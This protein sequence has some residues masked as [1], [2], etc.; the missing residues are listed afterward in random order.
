MKST[1][2]FRDQVGAIS[3]WFEGWNTCEQSVAL[4]SLLKKLCPAQARFLALVLEQSYAPCHD[5]KLQE[6]EAND[7]AYISSLSHESKDR[8]VAYLL[9][10]L[11]LLY[12]GNEEA[13]FQYLSLIPKVLAHSIENSVHIEE[14]R[15]LLSYSLIHPAITMEDRRSLSQWLR[16]LE[17]R[18]SNCSHFLNDA[19]NHY[20]NNS[21]VNNNQ[22]QQSLHNGHHVT[23]GVDLQGDG[24]NGLLNTWCSLPRDGDLLTPVGMNGRLNG[25]G[26]HSLPPGF[27]GTHVPLHHM[28]SAPP[29]GSFT[30]V[31]QSLPPSCLSGGGGLHSPPNY[32]TTALHLNQG[33]FPS[34]EEPTPGDWLC[35]D[36]AQSPP[37]GAKEPPHAPLS[38]QSSVTSSGSGSESHADEHKT[39]FNSDCSG[40]KDVPAWLKS[41]RLHKYAHLF[42]K[43]SYEEMLNLSETQL[44]SQHVTK[45]ARHKIILSVVKLRERPA[46]LQQL[47]KEVQE[48]GSLKG[49][50]SELRGLIQTPIRSYNGPPSLA[51]NACQEEEGDR[52]PS[53]TSPTLFQQP[54]YFGD[55]AGMFTRVMGKVCANLLVSSRPENECFNMFVML[56][57]KC[58]SHEAFTPTHKRRLFSW[59]QQVQ[60]VWHPLPPRRTL[61]SRQPKGKWLSP[62]GNTT[63]SSTT[64]NGNGTNSVPGDYTPSSLANGSSSSPGG[65]LRTR[66]LTPQQQFPS[67][68]GGV[69]PLTRQH[70]FLQHSGSNPGGLPPPHRSPLSSLVIKRPSLQDHLKPHVAVQRTHSAP[71]S[72]NPLAASVLMGKPMEDMSNDPELNTRL[73]SLCLSMT[74]HALGALDENMDS[75]S[76]IGNKENAKQL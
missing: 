12:P 54:N 33:A 17:D 49:V 47:E 39:G 42:S 61:D 8:A 4:Y 35:C 3:Q 25:L 31:S 15:Q 69:R 9:S 72:F 14:S 40:M 44:E 34:P 22:Q 1:W 46:L 53:P 28:N 55:L 62:P 76:N 43:M 21:N 13:K 37:G 6:Q 36:V 59:K 11:P 29:L 71:V 2:M 52:S 19:L 48:G 5:L 27:G 18:I 38:P 41:L 74:E 51:L 26:S 58:L 64:S 60:K 57:D 30:Q 56:I 7:P 20:N 16:H 65:V 67:S 63:S 68:V 70:A 50:L 75:S 23:T 10:H 66:R 73:E 24:H 45:G 32:T